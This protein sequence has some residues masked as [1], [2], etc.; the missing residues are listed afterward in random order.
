[1]GQWVGQITIGKATVTCAVEVFP[2]RG[3][4]AFLVGKPIQRL[5]GAI[6]NHAMDEVSI[7]NKAGYEILVNEIHSNHVVDILVYVGLRPTSDI[8]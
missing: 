3:S 8:K 2:S 4:W 6:H 5:F 1:M 7:P